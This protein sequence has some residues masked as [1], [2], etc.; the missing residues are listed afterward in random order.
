[1][2]HPLARA[3]ETGVTLELNTQ[4][5]TLALSRLST[6]AGHLSSIVSCMSFTG[7]D[8][9]SEP[10]SGVSSVGAKVGDT[11]SSGG[12]V[13]RSGYRMEDNFKLAFLFNNN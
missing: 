8:V 1:M 4:K 11:T 3:M 12:A 2:Q 13:A 5:E 10:T 6:F 7:Q 9:W